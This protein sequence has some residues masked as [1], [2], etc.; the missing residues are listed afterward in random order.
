MIEALLRRLAASRT[1]EEIDPLDVELLSPPHKFL[2]HDLSDEP[3]AA[4][5]EHAR[6]DRCHEPA[7]IVW[8]VS[9]GSCAANT[10]SGS[11]AHFICSRH[12]CIAGDMI[13]ETNGSLNFPTPW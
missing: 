4:R 5:H 1:D 9:R 7:T 11:R 2:E 10:P 12:L 3:G 6:A 8:C 13:S